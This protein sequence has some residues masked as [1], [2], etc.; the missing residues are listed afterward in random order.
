MV[1]NFIN[2]NKKFKKISNK[3]KIERFYLK[4]P[5]ISIFIESTENI[6]FDKNINSEVNY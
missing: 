4:N 2:K 6:N 1:F 5:D 3:R